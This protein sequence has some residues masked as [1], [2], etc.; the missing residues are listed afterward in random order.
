MIRLLAK[1]IFIFVLIYA[2]VNLWYAHLEER[3]LDDIAALEEALGQP[4]Q[5]ILKEMQAGDV[6]AT[7]ADTSLLTALTGYRAEVDVRTGVARFVDWYRG[8]Y[9]A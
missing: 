8:Y 7:W 1:L 9:S 6:P 5:K 3:L 4:A 2:G